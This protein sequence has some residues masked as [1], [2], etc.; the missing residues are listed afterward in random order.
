MSRLYRVVSD[1]GP[2]VVDVEDL[3]GVVSRASLLALDGAPVKPGDWVVVHS[4]YVI[5]RV[6]AAAAK[7]IADE[8]RGALASSA[9][10]SRK[11]EP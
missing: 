8:V 5:D 2:G 3:S 10:P 6:D 7:E 11:V 4:G 1:A 9:T